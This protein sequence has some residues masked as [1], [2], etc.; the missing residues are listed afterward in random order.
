MNQLHVYICPICFGFPAH[1]GHHIA[2]SR[3]PYAI[4]FSLV[5]YFIH[6]VEFRKQPPLDSVFKPL[7]TTEGTFAEQNH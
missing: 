7:T 6:D 1:L 3:V 5:I 2:L 4:G